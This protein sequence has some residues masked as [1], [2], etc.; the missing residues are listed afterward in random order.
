MILSIKD[1]Y[2]GSTHPILLIVHFTIYAYLKWNIQ[3]TSIVDLFNHF[4]YTVFIMLTIV[5]VV[6]TS[7]LPT[8]I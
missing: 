4:I 7:V 5:R 3:V 8:A 2:D 1:T 6:C